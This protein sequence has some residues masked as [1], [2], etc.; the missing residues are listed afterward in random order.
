MNSKIDERQGSKELIEFITSYSSLLE[1][2]ISLIRNVLQDTVEGVMNGIQEIS[3]KTEERTK[4]AD[5]LLTRSFEK[6]HED[7]LK[8]IEI[9]QNRVSRIF[10]E[11]KIILGNDTQK[12]SPQRESQC[13]EPVEKLEEELRRSTSLY[14]KHLESIGILDSE[15][16]QYLFMIMGKLSAD[17]VISQRLHHVVESIRAM[18]TSLSYVLID[19]TQRC[20][21]QEI[22]KLK[23]D[24]LSFTYDT[25]SM[26]AER[27]CFED[28]F[29]TD[30]LKKAS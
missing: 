12:P 9:S 22:D 3:N 21:P 10:E 19:Y 1:K 17:D 4:T 8:A 18:T 2:Q 28:H 24:L 27:K 14:T 20:S 29:S 25:Y 16:E 15:V 11:A 5:K 13:E 7:Q 26:E 23:K 30:R 6:P